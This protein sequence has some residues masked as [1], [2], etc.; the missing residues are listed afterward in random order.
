MGEDEVLLNSY[1]KSI[2]IWFMTIILLIVG[3]H[4]SFAAEELYLV[5]IRESPGKIL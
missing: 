3:G 4:S 1:I 5:D 2:F